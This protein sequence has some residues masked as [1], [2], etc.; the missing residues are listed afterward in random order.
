M[1]STHSVA[2]VSQFNNIPFFIFRDEHHHSHS[3]VCISMVTYCINPTKTMHLDVSPLPARPFRV[4]RRYPTIGQEE[5]NWH[6][7]FSRV[8]QVP[9]VPRCRADVGRFQFFTPYVSYVP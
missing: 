3:P 9:R 6:R 1:R 5:L 7:I 2:E 4:K 8:P